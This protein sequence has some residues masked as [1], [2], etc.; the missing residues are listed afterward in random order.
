MKVVVISN[1]DLN[2]LNS[3]SFSRL[4]NYARAVNKDDCELVLTSCHYPNVIY[5]FDTPGENIVFIPNFKPSKAHTIILKELD[6]LGVYKYY[7]WVRSYSSGKNDVF[8]LY[9]YSFAST[10]VF[11]LIRW[12][13]GVRIFVEKNE[14]E[15]AIRL[16]AQMPI[17]LLSKLLFI[18]LQM[19]NIPLSVMQDLLHSFFSGLIVIS[20]KLGKLYSIVTK[21]VVYVP[22]LVDT[23]QFMPGISYAEHRQKFLLTF[24][25]SITEKKDKLYELVQ[26]I[27]SDSE[28]RS[29]FRLQIYGFINNSSKQRLESLIVK[30]GMTDEIR[31]FN[32]VPH[33]SMAEIFSNSDIL[34]LIRPSNLQNEYGFSTKLAEYLASGTPVLTT[35]V[36]DN[37]EYLTDN[38]NAFVLNKNNL[39]SVTLSNKLKFIMNN[40]GK[41]KE[42]GEGGRITAIKHFDYRI[43]SGTLINFFREGLV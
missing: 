25:G 16:N 14:L 29:K 21:N 24:A 33:N 43:Y 23:N 12:F 6:F 19:I 17:G 11:L 9:P 10:L 34:L 41:L 4:K 1:L 15:V 5:L 27:S 18:L 39:D 38:L 7:R 2:D 37:A 40:I 8:L 42:I 30:Y 3:G 20:K 26:I 28:L 31:L 13:G 32:P 22:V 35:D 36:S